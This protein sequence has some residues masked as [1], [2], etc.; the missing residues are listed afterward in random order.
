MIV[1]S[2][3]SS[4]KKILNNNQNNASNPLR[5]S[6]RRLY[7]NKAAMV[8]LAVFLIICFLCLFAPFITDFAYYQTNNKNVLALPTSEHIFGTD[9]LGR[10]IFARVLY[11]GR[12]TLRAGIVSTILAAVT[13]T[14]I[15]MVSGYFGGKTDFFLARLIDMLA[16]VPSLLLIIVI[17][18]ALGWGKGNFM[19]AM[20]ISA[21]PQFARLVRASVLGVMGQDYIE[22]ARA[23]GVWH[24]GIIRNH[25][26][27]SVLSPVFIQF[28]TSMAE[29]ILNCTIL[30]YLGVGV[31]PPTPE[32]GL[33]AYTGK[34]YMLSKPHVAFFP[35]LIIVVCVISVNFFG[36][37]L[38]DAL[39][40]RGSSH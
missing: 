38:R 30:G 15:G 7:K 3:L 12:I 5:E 8:G 20:A 32:W 22:A 23:L 19:Y 9:H 33:L 6:L 29:A 18:I 25:L 36:N 16:A 2:S 26:L 13:G 37:G 10:D 11:G 21:I 14:L 1:R 27:H 24:S 31:N 34:S 28:T 4:T 40:P 39:D 17:E 35:C